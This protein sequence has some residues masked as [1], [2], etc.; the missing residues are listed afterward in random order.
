MPKTLYYSFRVIKLSWDA[1]KTY[2]AVIL[3]SNI[4]SSTFYP[5][6][7]V[8]ILAQILGSLQTR[9]G[10]SSYEV[11][12]YGISFATVSLVNIILNAFVNFQ[13]Y[14]KDAGFDMYIDKLII[15]KLATL[16]PQTFENPSFQRLITEVEAA[17][18]VLNAQIERFT[19]FVSAIA[20][21]LTA[22]AVLIPLFPTFIP[23]ILLSIIPAYYVG[24][25]SRKRMW[26]FFTTKRA[27]V[28]RITQYVKNLLSQDSTSKEA[29][30][31]H[32][33]G[34]LQNKVTSEQHN[35]LRDFKKVSDSYA[36]G[37][38]GSN[39]FQHVVFLYTQ[40]VNLM[41]V[42]GGSLG[43]GQ[44]TL[45]FQQSQNLATGSQGILDMYSSMKNRILQ[46]EK[47]FSFFEYK[48]AITSPDSPTPIPQDSLPPKIEFV[49]VS[50]AYPKTKRLILNNFSLTINPGEK[51]ALVGENG[52]GKTTIVKLLLRFYDVTDG[53]ILI[54]GVNI[55]ELELSGWHNY[56]GALFQDFIKYQFTYKENVCFGNITQKNNAELFK[57]ALSHSGANK[58]LDTMPNGVQQIVGKMF[59]TGIDLSGGQWQKLAL[60]RA[61]FRDAPILILD[62]PTSAIDAKAEYEIFEGVQK[63]QKDKTVIIISHRFSTVRNADR[64]LVLDEGKIIEEGNHQK[65]MH[66][67]GLY[68]E[69]F[70]L[71]AKGY[72]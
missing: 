44:F 14:Y 19:A 29:S 66:K 51:I 56:I 27:F 21:T 48:P 25:V 45:A 53:K 57:N 13:G 65:L 38:L 49:N 20:K 67:K 36:I 70:E 46:I 10:I 15:Q 16:D 26:P 42:I 31:F 34:I 22:I 68:A 72:K 69:L 64:I 11:I 62:E 43:I 4:Y 59:D 61:F 24:D 28:N 18:G 1:N 35:Y 9:H 5:F 71:Q 23:L 60:A 54:N 37:L 39:I 12:F 41:A 55:R 3:F 40:Y 7:Q 33:G 63:L 6:F 17:R 2:T 32:T 8:Y 50:F 52:A 58:F 30:I 47:F